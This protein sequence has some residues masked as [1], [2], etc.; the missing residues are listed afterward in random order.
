MI[1]FK[2]ERI[3][4]LWGELAPL[5]PEHWREVAYYADIP[6]DPDTERYEAIENAGGL[7]CYTARNSGRLVGYAF[8]FVGPHLHYKGAVVAQ[9]DVLY[10][11]RSHRG[12]LGLKLIMWCDEQLRAEHV[13]VVTHHVKNAPH[14]N[15]GP[16]LKRKGYEPTD[17]LWSRRLDQ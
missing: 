2:R 10:V 1:E 4:D 12:G 16:L 15:F 14:L 5:L 17:T 6:L 13:Q 11:E 7:R 9:Q 8:Y 3:H